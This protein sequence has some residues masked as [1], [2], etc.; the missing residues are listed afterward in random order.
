MDRALQRE[1]TLPELWS[2]HM[3][4]KGRHGSPS[5]RLLLQ[6]AAGEHSHAERILT[7]LLRDAG[8]TGWRS[9]VRVGAY[10][11]DV[12]FR[13]AKVVIEVDGWA[14]HSDQDSFQRDRER[15]NVLALQGW[16]VL[17]F[18]WL[19]LAEYPERVIATVRAAIRV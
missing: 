17:R 4:N 10:I 11:V 5:A 3:R 8:I 2:A 13:A 9:N 14:F 15:Q 19:D 18:T 7:K 1:S 12:L 16:Q 6:A